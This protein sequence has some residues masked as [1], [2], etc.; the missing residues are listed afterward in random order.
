MKPV[1]YRFSHLAM[2]TQFEVLFGVPAESKGVKEYACQVAQ[3][4]FTEIDRTEKCLS[5]F[6]ESSDISRLNKFGAERPVKVSVETFDCLRAARRAYKDTDGAFDV[7]AQRGVRAIGTN[8]IELDRTAMT[9]RLRSKCSVD[10]GGIGKGFALDAAARIIADWADDE[11]GIGP[12]FLHGGASSVLAVGTPPGEKG[13]I[14]SVGTGA[15]RDGGAW[16]IAVRD[17]AISSSGVEVRSGHIIE[18]ATGKAAVTRCRVWASVGSNTEMPGAMA[19]ALSTAFMITPTAVI[20]RYCKEHPGA[21]AIVLED[22]PEGP[23]LI[24]FGKP[25]SA[26]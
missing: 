21:W 18:P 24:R 14:V 26:A 10:L 3:A 5:R 25:P 9:V 13:W 1:R 16:E 4:V 15:V 20:D 23:N 8:A 7:T 12:A 22:G 11:M 19:D 17:R 6:I 2:T